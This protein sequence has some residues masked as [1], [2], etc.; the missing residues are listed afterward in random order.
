MKRA[1][2]HQSAAVRKGHAPA[3]TGRKVLRNFPM[4]FKVE[5]RPYSSEDQSQIVALWKCV[6]S[7]DP[8][9]SDP[10]SMIEKKLSVQPELFLL[11]HIDGQS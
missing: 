11:A 1:T 4:D 3:E 5:I 6:F 7:Y 9:W 2:Q 8:P 10:L